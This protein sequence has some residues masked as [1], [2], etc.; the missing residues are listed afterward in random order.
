MVVRD[1]NGSRG[2][3]IGEIELLVQIGL[4]IFEIMFH[5]MDIVPAYSCLLGR[6]WIYSIGVEPSTLH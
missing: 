5:V 1:F 4:A 3:M 2:E 6:Q